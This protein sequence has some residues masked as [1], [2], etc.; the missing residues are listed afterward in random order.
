MGDQLLRAAAK[1]EPGRRA[2]RLGRAERR[3]EDRAGEVGGGEEADTQRAEDAADKVH[4]RRTDGIV[5]VDLVEEQHGEEHHH[6]GNRADQERARHIGVSRTGR[7][8]HQARQAAVER[9]ADI[10]L[11]EQQPGGERGGKGCGRGGRIGVHGNLRG[12]GTAVTSHAHR[13]T[14]VESEPA[15]P[16]HE[17]ADEGRR[18]VVARDGVDPAIGAVLAEAGPQDDRTCE[19]RPAAH[20]V[21]HR[22]AG[23]VPEVPFLG[24]VAEAPDPVA[25]DRIDRDRHDEGEDDEGVVLDSLGNGSRHDRRG[26]SREDELEEKLRVERHVRPADRAIHALIL[27]AHQRAVVVLRI[28]ATDHPGARLPDPAT[29]SRAKH[30]VPAN[31]PEGDRRRREDDE[32]LREDVDAVLRPCEAGL[33]AAEPEVHEEH[34]HAAE[35]HPDGVGSSPELFH[36]LL[37]RHQVWLI[38]GSSCPGIGCS[39]RSGRL[40]DRFFR[41]QSGLRHESHQRHHNGEPRHR[42][43]EASASRPRSDRDHRKPRAKPIGEVLTTSHKS[44]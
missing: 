42:R 18:H 35:Q 38:S 9:H 1:E 14:R 11:P 32:V 10:G 19:G 20:G 36:H 39:S 27:V 2:A 16:E 5:D 31:Q 22:A 29:V 43:H 26:G 30:Q 44:P 17:A 15:E 8:R 25:D 37:H 3:V 24:E 6:P 13:A 41:R 33:H 4:A 23:K 28:E 40:G 7:D 12:Q 34:E 21:H